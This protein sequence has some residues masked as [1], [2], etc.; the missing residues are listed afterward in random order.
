MKTN[1]ATLNEDI[2]NLGE[3]LKEQYFYLWYLNNSHQLLVGRKL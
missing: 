1:K 2:E 3:I